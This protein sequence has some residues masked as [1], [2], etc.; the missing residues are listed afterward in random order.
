MDAERVNTNSSTADPLLALQPMVV[1]A[2]LRGWKMSALLL[3]EQRRL[4][5]G[6]SSARP[7]ASR[8]PPPGQPAP[9]GPP[10]QP[11]WLLQHPP[12]AQ[13]LART[14]PK[15]TSAAAP[16]LHGGQAPDGMEQHHHP[17]VASN[18]LLQL[19]HR[20]LLCKIRAVGSHRMPRHVTARH[21]H[22]Q[23]TAVPFQPLHLF[24]SLSEDQGW[25][26]QSQG[27]PG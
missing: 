26:V 4:P 5:Q 23:R 27:S 19:V 3:T 17:A 24:A 18:Y 8:Q 12:S 10:A 25:Q 20:V 21:R 14:L 13:Q 6:L 9:R 15:P 2:Q 1:Q 22:C 16:L 11:G 7:H